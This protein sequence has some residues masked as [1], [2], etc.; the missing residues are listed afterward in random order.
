MWINFTSN[1]TINKE[2]Q[3]AFPNFLF[4]TVIKL[5]TTFKAI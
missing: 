4:N 3:V 5:L 1:Y 2:N